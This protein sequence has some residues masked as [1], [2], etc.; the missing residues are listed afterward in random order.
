M[1]IDIEKIVTAVLSALLP[2]IGACT[3]SSAD[4]VKLGTLI[5]SAG[6]YDRSDTPVIFDCSA[7]DLVSEE[8]MMSGSRFVLVEHGSRKEIDAQ[9]SAEAG[10]GWQKPGTKGELIWLLEG[11]TGKGTQ[12][13]F[14]LYLKSGNSE[15][16]R[17][18]IEDSAGQHLL[19][20]YLDRPVLQYNYGVVREKAGETG[21]YDRSSYL[22]P[23]WTPK[24]QVVTGDFSP[25]H[26]HQ[27]GIF[28]AWRPVKFGEVE[29]DFWG[30]GEATGRV[31]KDDSAIETNVGPV[32]AEM[33]IRND[34]TVE[35]E[36]YFKELQVIRTYDLMS[37]D[38]WLF[39]IDVTQIP[40]DPENPEQIPTPTA[41]M[42]LLQLYYGGMSYRGPSR[43][44]RK[45]AR[46][47]IRSIERGVV[48]GDMNW[49]P[50]DVSLDILTR[51]GKGRI[52]GDRTATGW[53]DFTG[54]L[55]AGWGG[56]AMFDHSSNLR[57][58]T[59]V[60]IHPELPYFSWAF[61]QNEPYTITSDNPLTLR[62]RVLV[63]NGHPDRKMNERIAADYIDP[64]EVEWQPL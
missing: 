64:P 4:E 47:V 38:V 43:W 28:I 11:M 59:P 49:L 31:L 17:L 35:D 5:V 18:K 61:V 42:E 34:G 32:F 45:D 54:Q 37:E 62:Y 20:K 44:L 48:F 8:A 13:E 63:H 15:S 23:V 40:V 25:E 24:G 9:W 2:C 19:L 52:E 7:P 53:V 36:T 3:G 26:I 55:R 16:N 10:F 22:H 58:P 1:R 39:D 30:L 6:A 57:Y 41:T 12:R 56:V 60:R 51:E 29:T 21:P 27:R 14:D 33:V 50:E 46:D